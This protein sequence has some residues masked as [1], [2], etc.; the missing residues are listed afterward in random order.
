M[1]LSTLNLDILNEIIIKLKYDKATLFKLLLTNKCIC[2]LTVPILWENPFKYCKDDE[3]NYLVIEIYIK[4]FN[5]EER[6]ELNKDNDK[7]TNQYNDRPFLFEYRKTYSEGFSEEER[8]EL[9]KV[10]DKIM[11]QNNDTPLLFEYGKYLKELNVCDLDKVIDS[12]IKITEKKNNLKNRPGF[13]MYRSRLTDR[14]SNLIKGHITHSI[15]RQCQKLNCLKLDICLKDVKLL[16][17]MQH[18]IN[19]LNNLIL[20]YYDDNCDIQ[21]LKRNFNILE[22][23]CQNLYSLKIGSIYDNKFTQDFISFVKSKN[24]LNE[25]IFNYKYIRRYNRGVNN[26]EEV[27]FNDIIT[28][29]L[30]SMANSLTKVVLTKVDLSNISFDYFDKCINLEILVL[31]SNKGLKFEDNESYTS[32]NNL[33]KL[34]LSFN[35][36]STEVTTWIIKK[37]GNNLSSLTIGENVD[38]KAINIDTLNALME[39]CP[40]INSLSVSGI[41]KE[42]YSIFFSCLKNFKL[43]TLQLFQN[44]LKGTI[45]NSK[46]LLNYIKSEKSLSTLGIGKNDD[47]WTFYSSKRDIFANL[48]K[49]HNVRLVLYNKPRY[50]HL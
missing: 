37:A 11:N 23:Y 6:N 32:F 48:L 35:D 46:D 17:Y 34:D 16:E 20:Y 26:D 44:K 5:E 2:K 40:N 24:G 42:G 9:N 21:I 3:K 30:E 33:K 49:N 38:K 14:Y 25:F 29:T 43:I 12:W 36:W 31:S 7:I 1:S 39:F 18:K 41:S 45:M 4:G 10:N 50:S 28:S 22:N 47:Y 13:L 19:D 27:K 8:K 15:M